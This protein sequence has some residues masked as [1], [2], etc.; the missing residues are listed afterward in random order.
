[1]RR[2]VVF[3]FGAVLFRWQPVQLL[4][5]NLPGHANTEAQA[6]AW[7]ARIFQRFSADSD[8]AR[9]DLEQIRRRVQGFVGQSSAQAWVRFRSAVIGVTVFAGQSPGDKAARHL[10]LGHPHGEPGAHV[11]FQ[12]D[13]VHVVVERLL[14]RRAQHVVVDAGGI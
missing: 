11:F 3:D 7:A 12:A 1:M 5:Q 13:A 14:Q 8:W 4:M 10:G 9:F 2:T 6:K